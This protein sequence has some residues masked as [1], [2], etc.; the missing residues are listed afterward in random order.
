MEEMDPRIVEALKSRDPEERKK[1]V[2]ALAQ[3]HTAESLRYLATI[4]KKDPDP[5]V[6]D[7]AIKAGRHIKKERAAADWIGGEDMRFST[8]EQPAVSSGASAVAQEQAKGLMDKALDESV[9]GNYE[10]AEQ[11]ARQAFQLNPDLQYDSYYVGVASDV[12]GMEADEAVATLL[13]PSEE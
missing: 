5:G 11:Y 6:R 7:L 8:N 3:T 12:M 13:T 2:R 9:K 1:A 10:K 4:Y